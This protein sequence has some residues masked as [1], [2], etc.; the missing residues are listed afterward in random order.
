[1]TLEQHGLLEAKLQ[2]VNVDRVARDGDAVP[3]LAHRPVRRPPRLLQAELDLLDLSGSD[4]WLLEDGPDAL[5]RLDSIVK[6]L[7]L[8]VVAGLA[9]EVVKLPLRGVDVGLDPAVQDELHA[10][11]RHL[12]PRDVGHGGG[13]ELGASGHGAGGGGSGGSRRAGA[14]GRSPRLGPRDKRR[15]WGRLRAPL[16]GGGDRR[17]GRDGA[18]ART[19]EE[20]PPDHC[21]VFKGIRCA[22]E[23]L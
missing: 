12:L 14:A 8:R 16:A 22:S 10:V 2:P 3:P 9:G 17:A 6:H 13:D 18:E 20:L 23:F 19:R 5:A 4:G 1:M 15:L 7:V 21:R 11:V